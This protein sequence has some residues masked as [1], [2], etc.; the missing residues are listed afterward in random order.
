MMVSFLV[1]LGNMPAK[2]AGL[3]L[4]EYSTNRQENKS[5]GCGV[6]SAE[7]IGEDFAENGLKDSF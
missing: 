6:R 4:D 1:M 3:N 2:Q 5:I 7:L